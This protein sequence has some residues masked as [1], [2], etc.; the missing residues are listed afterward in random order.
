MSEGGRECEWVGLAVSGELLVVQGESQKLCLAIM[1]RSQ[2]LHNQSLSEYFHNSTIVSVLPIIAF[3]FSGCKRR[4][5]WECD[6]ML[7]FA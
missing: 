3:T 5:F 2:P 4:F 7:C 6:V 1:V